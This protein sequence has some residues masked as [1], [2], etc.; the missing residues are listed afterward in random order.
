MG[1]SLL[2]FRFSSLAFEREVVGRSES[3]INLMIL[4]V[5]YHNDK[6]SNILSLYED[7]NPCIDIWLHQKAPKEMISSH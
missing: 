3:S 4:S 1:A 6:I 7:M 5:T 2:Q